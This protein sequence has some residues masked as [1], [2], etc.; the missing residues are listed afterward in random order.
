MDATATDDAVALVNWAPILDA[1]VDGPVGRAEIA[2]LAGCSRATAYRATSELREDGLLERVDDGYRLTGEGAAVLAQARQFVD[3]IAGVERLRPLLEYV[4]HPELVQLAAR[5]AA[6]EVVVPSD[7]VPYRIENRMKTIIENTDE[8]MVG[9]TSGLGSPALAE[10]MFERLQ[11][12][13]SVDW[14]I[15]PEMYD[16]FVATYG[17]LGT[18]AVDD[19]AVAVSVADEI[20]VD[21]AIYDET[22]VLLGFDHDRGVLGAVAITDDP[23]ALQWGLDIVEERRGAAERAE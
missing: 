5:L 2:E 17:E 6:A 23:V 16:Q 19:G 4:D 7:S 13:V 21:L 8:R 10:A 1:C 9:L 12:G 18:H 11:A 15:Q 14:V 20:P 3:G 22:L